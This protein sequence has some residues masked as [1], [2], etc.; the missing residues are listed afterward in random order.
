MF[1]AKV[2]SAEEDEEVQYGDNQHVEYQEYQVYI[3][4]SKEARDDEQEDKKETAQRADS[5]IIV[6]DIALAA[7][8]A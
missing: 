2:L 1:I 4:E 5:T 7:V 6:G 8:S 3:E